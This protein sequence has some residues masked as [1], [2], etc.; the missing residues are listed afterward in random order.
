MSQA[1]TAVQLRS[2]P[3]FASIIGHLCK[4][5]CGSAIC[6][7]IPSASFYKYRLFFRSFLCFLHGVALDVP[8]D[9]ESLRAA[10]LWVDEALRSVADEPWTVVGYSMGV[11]AYGA[12]SLC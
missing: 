8:Y 6:I 9:V 11:A 5:S 4:N 7:A 10:A 2:P 1:W 12:A 3:P